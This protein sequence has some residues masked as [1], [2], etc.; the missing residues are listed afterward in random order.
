MIGFHI[1][2][3]LRRTDRIM[4]SYTALSLSVC[5]VIGPLLPGGGAKLRPPPPPRG[6]N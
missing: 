2:S 6:V 1:L 5:W 3:D 4:V